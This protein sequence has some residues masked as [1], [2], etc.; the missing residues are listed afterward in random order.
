MGFIPVR[1][2]G[3]TL[4]EA[5]MVIVIGGIIAGMVAIFIRQPVDA[6]LDANRRAELTDTADTALRRMARDIRKAL[7]NSIRNPGPQCIEFI[8]TKTGGRYRADVDGSGNGDI[9]DFTTA[10]GQF[11]LLGLNSDLPADQ[12]I[13]ANDVIAIY[14]LGFAGADA[15]NGDNTALVSAVGAGSLVNETRITIA[16]KRFPLESLGHRFFVIPGDEKV[17]AFVCH[18]GK[19]YRNSNYAYTLSCPTTGGVVLAQNVNTCQFTY[20]GTD[21]QRN[22]LVRMTIQLSKDGETVTLY[23]EAH[24]NNTP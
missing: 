20:N 2:A 6:Y 11:D 16:A 14:N 1:A 17:V 10:D 5:V 19:I 12:Q 8:P 22:A 13:L 4:I 23:H 15:Y 21:L 3:F 24:V 18:S 7:P 9:L